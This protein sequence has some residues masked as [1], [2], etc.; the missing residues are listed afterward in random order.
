[1]SLVVISDNNLLAVGYE[2]DTFILYGLKSNFKPLVR[3][4]GH[5]SFVT[6]VR[7]DNY[8]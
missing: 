2:D 6:Q 5:K 4:I 3:G 7:F 1:M 8:L